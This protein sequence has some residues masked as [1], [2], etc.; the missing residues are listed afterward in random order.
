MQPNELEDVMT[1]Y[2]RDRAPARLL[3][4]LRH[5]AADHLA[6]LPPHVRATRLAFFAAAVRGDDATLAE[7]RGLS[8]GANA[9]GRAF[10]D[11]VLA[12]AVPPA[13]R[14]PAKTAQD[15]DARWSEFFATGD[16]AP[17]RE[18]AEV[19]AWPDRLRAHVTGLLT[20]KR[21]TDAFFGSASKRRAELAARLQPLGVRVDVD[22]GAVRNAADLDCLTLLRG[23][24]VAPD[25]VKALQQAL[26]SPLGA[27]D[28]LHMSTKT[29]ALWS[30]A[31]NGAR[32]A[33]VLDV[34][35][36]ALA[37]AEGPARL[38]LLSALGHARLERG[39]VDEARALADEA[40][41]AEPGDETFLALRAQAEE[42]VARRAA[43]ELF[44]R[45]F[46]AGEPAGDTS[47]LRSRA[48][49]HAPPAFRVFAEV[50]AAGTPGNPKA[51]GLTSSW[52]VTFRGER[53]K[54]WRWFWSEPDGQA[55]ADR[56]VTLGVAHYEN[57]GLWV[58]FPDAM[59]AAE[60]RALQRDHFLALTGR[61][62][63]DA[64]RHA[65]GLVA[66]RYEAA[67]LAALA[68]VA[69]L[70]DGR[71]DATLWLRAS[72][73]ALVAASVRAGGVER[74]WARYAFLYDDAAPTI[75]APADFIDARQGMVKVA[76][77]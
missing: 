24:E 29:S 36:E 18:I 41:A 76:K 3:Q 1:G 61:A 44:V 12:E 64:R 52:D 46:E 16:A 73:G 37:K 9:A 6:K 17:V 70:P 39:D 55:L 28:L 5:V 71:G 45:S 23:T 72:D 40:L 2:Y 62:P 74:P 25:K 69:E 63:D 60:Q 49:S 43:R 26:P 47:A 33:P 56:W 68:P 27:P 35:A 42:G 21:W 15:L 66:L 67:D 13:R 51:D 31:S 22:A 38:S 30:L 14:G 77:E 7:V 4:A 75:E 19:L 8:D 58:R 34:C 11:E 20:E 57:P 10:L 65:D 54:G 48:R 59:R 32:H 50:R 53:S